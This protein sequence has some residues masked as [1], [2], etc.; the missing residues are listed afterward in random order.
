MEKEKIMA[1]IKVENL[2]YCYPNTTKLALDGL[3]F[4]IE[5]GSFIGIIGENGAGKT[6]LVKLLKGLLKPVGGSIYYGGS[7]I[8]EKSVAMLAGEI[9][10]VFQNPDDQP[11]LTKLCQRLGYKKLY[12]SLELE[13]EYKQKRRFR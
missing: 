8:A 9:G 5:K 10:Y 6:T 13:K 11:Y 4:E 1:Y 2:K 7:D 3:D 12:F